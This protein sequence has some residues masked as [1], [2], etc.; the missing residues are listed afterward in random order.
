MFLIILMLPQPLSLVER[1]LTNPRPLLILTPVKRMPRQC[2]QHAANSGHM[3]FTVHVQLLANKLDLLDA[4]LPPGLLVSEG[5]GNQSRHPK[6]LGTMLSSGLVRR[7]SF[8]YKDVVDLVIND[9]FFLKS[10][11]FFSTSL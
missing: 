10:R 8:C 4:I 6:H 1:P 5:Q 11:F 3:T 9:D 7:D 2:V